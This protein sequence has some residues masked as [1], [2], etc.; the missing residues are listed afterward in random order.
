MKKTLTGAAALAAL[1]AGSAYAQEA[2]PRSDHAGIGFA[3]GALSIED[4]D[5]EFT[6]GKPTQELGGTLATWRIFADYQFGDGDHGLVVGASYFSTFGD[7]LQSG[8][9]RDGNLLVQDG[10]L[11]QLSGWEGRVG[12][13]FNAGGLDLMPYVAYGQIE[14]E[15]TTRQSCPG[16]PAASMNVGGYCAGGFVLAT[17]T[18]RAG[19]RSGDIDGSADTLS[20]GVELNLNRHAFIDV[21]YY[22]E[23]DFGEQI[24]TLEPTGDTAGQTAHP[25]TNPSQAPRFI[26]V[27]L[28]VRF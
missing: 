22:P 28:G 11:D 15:G 8:P 18:A 9:V 23:A 16:N 14:R 26:G 19:T 27:Q 13:A 2:P 10:T 5:Y 4:A 24:V 25:P 1:F 21:R 6:G 3:V 7:G 20:F 17:A 12:Y